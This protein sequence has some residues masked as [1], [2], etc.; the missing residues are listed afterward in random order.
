[1]TLTSTQ[2]RSAQPPP[3]PVRCGPSALTRLRVERG[4]S[5]WLEHLSRE[6][7][8]NGSLT[9]MLATGVRGVGAGETEPA[10][11][12]EVSAG[13][14]EQFSWLLGTGCTA[15]EAYWGMAA[16]DAQDA[17][18]AL[19]PLYEISQGQDG[20]MS[21]HAPPAQRRTS[22]TIT[23]VRQLHRLIDRPNLL[24]AVPATASG[25]Q[26]LQATVSA[27][28]NINA[29]S[30]FS[31]ARYAAVI[32]ANQTGL[33]AFV[34]SGGDPRTVYGLATFSLRPVDAEVDRRIE[35]LRGGSALDLCG[36]AATAQAILASR[37]CEE[38]FSTE[39]WARLA[40]RGA[41]PQRLVWDVAGR[42]RDG[43]H[44]LHYLDA[45]SVPNTVHLLSASTVTSLNERGL[46]EPGPGISAQEAA[47]HVAALGALGI[48]LDQVAA[49]LEKQCSARAQDPVAGALDRS[50][51]GSWQR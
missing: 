14:D 4:I 35:Q 6:E 21:L 40:R 11:A 47:E 3:A 15:Q 17:C 24:V 36:L 8:L 2:T 50:S 22:A 9:R 5:P 43:E 31:L 44:A 39:R 26:T 7:L 42:D 20:F 49:E 34:S 33:E 38:R 1:M 18:A 10:H 12:F 37:L 45:L 29:T 32:E 27:G 51:A 28:C 13:H 46:G 41:T 19:R 25:L 48:H 23:T 16:T 30:L